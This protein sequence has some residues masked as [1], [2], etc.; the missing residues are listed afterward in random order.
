[1]SIPKYNEMYKEFLEVLKDGKPHTVKE[2]RLAIGTRFQLTEEELSEMLPSGRQRVFD[3]RVGWCKTYLMK[4]DLVVSPARAKVMLTENGKKFLRAHETISEDELMKITSFAAFKKGNEVMETPASSPSDIIPESIVAEQTPQEI[5]EASVEK[6]NV[7][8]GGDLLQEI[9]TMDPYEFE[10][11]VVDLLVRMGYGKLQ[12]GSTATKKS[13]DEGIDGVVTA[14]KLGF[15]SIYIQ[16]KKYKDG[17][18]GRPDV[19]KFIGALAGQGAQKGIFITTSQFSKEAI[20]FAKK[21]LTYKIVL[22]D[23]AKLADLMIEYDLGVSTEYV[24]KVKRL[25]SDY[26]SDL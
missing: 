14:D 11:L 26:F 6:L 13:G 3:N 18:V 10:A 20:E 15:D 8:L 9:L 4:A 24:Y 2:V 1:M 23:G 21:N 22:I 16:A 12:Y 19:Q 7:A 25:D 5:I 17:T